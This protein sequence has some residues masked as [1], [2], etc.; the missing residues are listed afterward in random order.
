[1][2]PLIHVYLK[3]LWTKS[4]G[5]VG[6]SSGREVA[7]AGGL[8]PK[9]AARGCRAAGEPAWAG[10]LKH[11]TIFNKGRN[12]HLDLIYIYIC[13]LYVNMYRYIYIYV[14]KII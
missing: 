14:T 8:R 7:G 11:A 10:S 5:L 4:R 12:D 3:M 13:L 6:G 1:M 9:A 2:H